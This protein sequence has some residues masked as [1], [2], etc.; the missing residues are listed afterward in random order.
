M[1]ILF[2]I[3]SLFLFVFLFPH[4]AVSIDV[5]HEIAGIRL[6]TSVDDYPNIEYSNY[7]KEVVV[8]DWHGFRKG[9]ISYGICHTPGN[10]IKMR[11]KYENSTKRFFNTLMKRYKKKFGTPSEW[12]GDSFGIKHIW[13]WKFKDNE[14]N[15]VNLILQHNLQDNNDTIGNVIKLSYPEMV[16][17]ERLCFIKYCDETKNAEQKKQKETLKDSNWD[18]LIPK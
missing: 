2:K 17:Q 11:M 16:E 1:K 4:Q 6:G 18:Y 8:T 12:K 10:I 13:K 14:G 9:I 7:L 5:P 15:I 3:I